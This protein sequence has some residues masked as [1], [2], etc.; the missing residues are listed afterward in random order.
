MPLIS[1]LYDESDLCRNELVDDLADLLLSAAK[2]L[3][4]AQKFIEWQ[5]VTDF[6]NIAACQKR[7]ADEDRFLEL[8]K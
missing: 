1:D 3:E 8:L 6:N 7:K 5:R 2:A 4:F